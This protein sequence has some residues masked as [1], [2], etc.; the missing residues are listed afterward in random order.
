MN[1]IK[2]TRNKFH[3]F[4]AKLRYDVAVKK[5]DAA[6]EKTGER[7]YVMP[8]YQKKGKLVV[9]DRKNFRIL[10]SKHYIPRTALITENG[11]QVSHKIQVP[12]M[13]RECF[14]HTSYKDGSGKIT[15]EEMSDRKE[16]YLRW[17]IEK[18]YRNKIERH[19]R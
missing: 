14:Y 12:D 16:A 2:R 17:V 7:Y 8:T 6:H 9:V 18:D 4:V 3:I 13:I 10:K 19:K 11:E 5:A 15:D 1:F